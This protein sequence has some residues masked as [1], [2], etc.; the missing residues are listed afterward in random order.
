[1]YL[2]KGAVQKTSSI[3]ARDIIIDKLVNSLLTPQVI[4]ETVKGIG[5]ISTLL[6][7][8]TI[9]QTATDKRFA[10]NQ[11]ASKDNQSATD[12]RFADNQSATDKRFADNQSAADKRFT[13]LLKSLADLKNVE[14]LLLAEKL[15][16]TNKEVVP[17]KRKNSKKRIPSK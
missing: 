16:L 6:I 12:K 13:E 4:T 15:S 11:V 10:E 7:F 5:S 17:K 1:M 3:V 8:T 9:I 14:N 2:G